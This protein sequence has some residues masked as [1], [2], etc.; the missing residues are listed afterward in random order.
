MARY[1]IDIYV[2]YMG[3]P[4]GPSSHKLD[5][6]ADNFQAVLLDLK[7]KYRDD[8][9][10]MIY[11]LNLHLQQFRSRPELAAILQNQGKKGLPVVYINN[12]QAFQGRYPSLQEIEQLLSSEKFPA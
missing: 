11:A 7:N 8:I 12:H 1:N 3:C 4:C 2:P 9:S 6:Q 5:K 10:Y